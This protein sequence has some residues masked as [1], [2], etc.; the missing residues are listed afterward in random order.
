MQGPVLEYNLSF[1]T[2]QAL[3]LN[4][5]SR[6][7]LALKI[8]LF[9]MESGANRFQYLVPTEVKYSKLDEFTY[10]LI[11]KVVAVVNARFHQIDYFKRQQ[12]KQL[13]ST[14]DIEYTENNNHISKPSTRISL[15]M[16]HQS[17]KLNIRDTST[18]RIG[19]QFLT[20][21]SNN[22]FRTTKT[23]H[24]FRPPAYVFNFDF[25]IWRINECQ[26][27]SVVV[28]YTATVAPR[29]TMRCTKER[30]ASRLM[31]HSISSKFKSTFSF[32]CS[33]PIYILFFL[34]IK[35]VLDPL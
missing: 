26:K 19:T 9:H 2:D 12:L 22:H 15:K 29:F 20:F 14:L 27:V 8:I 13:L 25:T 1:L 28:N 32:D 17:F 31:L 10:F 35:I 3:D 21:V 7:D 18:L 4:F 24:Y 11:F 30:H 16:S 34:F 6:T 33:C 23:R 5:I